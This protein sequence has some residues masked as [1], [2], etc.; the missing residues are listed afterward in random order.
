MKGK[1][2]RGKAN[3]NRGGRS[4]VAPGHLPQ[5]REVMVINYRQRYQWDTSGGE[6][7][8]EPFQLINSIFCVF[9]DATHVISIVNAIRIRQVDL[10][11]PPAAANVSVAYG[12]NTARL[13]WV[14][15]DE[16]NPNFG[17]DYGVSDTTMSIDPAH[18]TLRPL[19]G[20]TSS[21]WQTSQGNQ[22]WQFHAFGV[23]GA[24]LDITFSVTLQMLEAISNVNAAVT[25]A[26]TPSPGVVYMTQLVHGGFGVLTPQVGNLIT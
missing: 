6:L 13:A 26:S 19:K 3:K 4:R 7:T 16:S 15:A 17:R 11:C 10:W 9:K 23:I 5:I 21:L 18:V 22:P 14:H 2:N 20:D 12:P 1:S 8:V 24:V 25:V